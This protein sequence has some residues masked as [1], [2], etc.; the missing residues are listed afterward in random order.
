MFYLNKK[1]LKILQAN[2]VYQKI[3]TIIHLLFKKYKEI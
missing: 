2:G 1:I 3:L